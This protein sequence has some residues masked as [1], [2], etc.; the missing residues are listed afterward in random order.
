MIAMPCLRDLQESFFDAIAQPPPE[1]EAAAPSA[2]LRVVRERP[3]L[4]ARA[5][6]AIYR[7]MYRARLLDVLRDDFPRT[8]TMLGDDFLAVAEAYLDSS[9]SRH[10]SVRWVGRAFAE[11]LASSLSDD[12]PSL[13]PDLARLE[14]ARLEVF[15]DADATPL[16]IDDLRHVPPGRWA[17]LRFHLIPAFRLLECH[18]PVQKIWAE[19]HPT[20]RQW[21][22]RTTIVRVW[23]Q[24]FAV[25]QARVDATELLALECVKANEPLAVLCE[26]IASTVPEERAAAVAGALVLRWAEDGILVAAEEPR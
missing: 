3:P 7:G 21:K 11:F 17:D 10:P 23:R 15:D 14:W 12:R 5:R 4:D 22:S 6:I 20:Q 24:G 19:P 2:L 1:T 13:T 18:W 25:Y 26:R 8:A 16:H 9:P